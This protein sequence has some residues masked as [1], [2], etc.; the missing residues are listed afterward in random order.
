MPTINSFMGD[1]KACNMLMFSW[2]YTIILIKFGENK[3]LE[4]LI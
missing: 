1:E 4:L 2:T 3:N